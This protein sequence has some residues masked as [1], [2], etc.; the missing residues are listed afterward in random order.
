MILTHFFMSNQKA[1][2]NPLIMSWQA[3]VTQ[4]M[5]GTGKISKGAIYGHNGGVWAASDGFKISDAE[6]K[7]IFGAFQNPS[8]I[9]ASGILLNGDKFFALRYD[10]R[11]IYGKRGQTG[12]VIVKTK[13]TILIGIYPES[14]QPGEAN[15]V[16]EGLGD[17]LIGM[18]Y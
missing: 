9:I 4:N 7:K 2:G 5:V 18:Q 16:M 6:F 14:V 8:E 12:C 17:Y 13:Q 15:K 10:D 11:S 3:Y 1:L